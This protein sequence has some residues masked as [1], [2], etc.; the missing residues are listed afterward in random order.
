MNA[1]VLAAA[2]LVAML[3]VPVARAASASDQLDALDRQEL[4]EHLAR[5]RTCTQARDFDCAGQQLGLARKFANNGA[6]RDAVQRGWQELELARQR[7]LSDDA[8]QKYAAE[9]SKLE[10]RN[11]AQRRENEEAAREAR[12]D[13]ARM[14]REGEK[15]QQPNT[16]PPSI[17]QGIAAGMAQFQR[18]SGR[19]SAIHNQAMQ[20]A[21]AAATPARATATAATAQTDDRDASRGRDSG[22]ERASASSAASIQTPVAA[23]APTTGSGAKAEPEPSARVDL[24]GTMHVVTYTKM[25]AK[26][27]RMPPLLVWQNTARI[28]WHYNRRRV[29]HAEPARRS[30]VE[31]GA[32]AGAELRLRRDLENALSEIMPRDYIIC[33]Q[34]KMPNGD[35]YLRHD[36]YVILEPTDARLRDKMQ[37]VEKSSHKLYERVQSHALT[38]PRSVSYRE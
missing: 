17:A 37:A 33:T 15:R 24:S 31:D 20:Q 4:N 1:S 27:G 5:A 9:Q 11:A 25:T 10:A 7:G 38:Y 30:Q 18:D 35:C 12:A 32:A 16:P 36:H 21:Q 34:G 19:L 28:D 29:S 26:L 14:T 2:A 23:A 22:N 6:D 13:A 3:G 8:R